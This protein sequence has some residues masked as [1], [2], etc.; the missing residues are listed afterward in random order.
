M[1]NN[2]GEAELITIARGAA[3]LPSEFSIERSRSILRPSPNRSRKFREICR[4]C[5]T[6][7]IDEQMK[8]ARHS[9]FGWRM[10]RNPRQN[11]L[12]APITGSSGNEAQISASE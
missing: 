1:L 6:C 3:D 5:A 8:V 9:H 10:I 4:I 2:V 12:A 11:S 7:F